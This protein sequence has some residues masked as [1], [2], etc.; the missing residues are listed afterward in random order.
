MCPN[1]INIWENVPKTFGYS[2]PSPF[3]TKNFKI[4]GAQEVPQ[5]FPIASESPPI[6]WKRSIIKLH[7]VLENIPY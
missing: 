6:L 2:Q 5:K 1:S 3:S 7:F 4:V